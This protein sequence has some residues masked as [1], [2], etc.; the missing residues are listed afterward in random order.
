VA[1]PLASVTLL[2][3]VPST[4]NFTVPLGTVLPEAAATVAVNVTDVPVVIELDDAVSV[5]VVAG[6]EPLEDDPPVLNP[7]A[8]ALASMLPSPEARSYPTP[9]L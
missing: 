2:S 8:S 7:N 6:S 4:A 5:V 9:A 1:A 3:S